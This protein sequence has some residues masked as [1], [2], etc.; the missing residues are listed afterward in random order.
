MP[1]ESQ[2]KTIDI[3]D[4]D[5]PDGPVTEIDREADAFEMP[6]PP[7]A[8]TYE[9]KLFL[10]ERGHQ[11]SALDPKDKAGTAYYMSWL[12]GRIIRPKEFEDRRILTNVT[13]TVFGGAV[14]SQ[15][16]T[17]CNRV[18]E[19]MGKTQRVEGKRSAKVVVKALGT[20]L[21]KE[22]IVAVECDWEA[23]SPDEEGSV[24]KRTGKRR[25]GRTIVRGMQNF[26][27]AEDGTKLPYTKDKFGTRC[28]ARLTV[29]KWLSKYEEKK[30]QADVTDLGEAFGDLAPDIPKVDEVN[31]FANAFG[32]GNDDIPF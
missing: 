6:P 25:V 21:Q 7:P 24:N 10:G 17:V 5:L 18:L 3:N 19:G 27:T 4:V 20:L 26:P 22:P 16:A 2:L 15:T 11:L 8:G 9:I 12:E 14:T 29:V 30:P 32:G 31:D 28:F 13:T 23:Y 1:E